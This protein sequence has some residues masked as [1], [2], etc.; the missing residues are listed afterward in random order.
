MGVLDARIQCVARVQMRTVMCLVTRT[1]LSG[2]IVARL[3]DNMWTEKPARQLIA[4]CRCWAH[5]MIVTQLG[6]SLPFKSCT[7]AEDR[8][9]TFH[10]GTAWPDCRN[11]QVS[12]SQDSAGDMSL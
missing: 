12:S 1:S 9:G 10:Q 6:M 4:V 11:R 5:K 8:A 2:G 3:I 7:R